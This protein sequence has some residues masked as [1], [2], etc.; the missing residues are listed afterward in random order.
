MHARTPSHRFA[1]RSM[2]ALAIV[3]TV[4]LGACGDDAEDDVD[5]TTPGVGDSTTV[6]VDTGVS[7]TEPSDSEPTETEPSTTG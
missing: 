5:T 7:E 4:G 6:P 2:A 1:R 3:A